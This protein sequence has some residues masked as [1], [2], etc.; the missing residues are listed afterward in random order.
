MKQPLNLIILGPQGSGKGTQA[1]LLASKFEAVFLGAG[2]LLR[3]IAKIDTSLGREV[4]QVINVEGKHTSAQLISRI[5]REKLKKVPQNRGVIMEGY[6]RN[7]EQYEIFKNFWP[8]LERA[9]YRVLF[10]ELSEA[11]AIKRLSK[12][13]V[14]ENCGRIYIAGALDKCSYCGGKLVA[15]PDDHPKAIKTRLELFDALTM[16]VIAEMEKEGKVIRIDGTPAV[17]KVHKQILQKL[18]L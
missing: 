7:L 13:V 12:R 18:D 2:D 3:G 16:P 8:K 6:P 10:I 11:E 4:H 9:D 17:E 15:R 1:A 5:F 14:C